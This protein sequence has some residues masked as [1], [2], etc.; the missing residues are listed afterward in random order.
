MANFIAKMSI[1]GA[2]PNSLGRRF[3][4]TALEQFSTIISGSMLHWRRSIT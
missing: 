3:M 2:S 1:L 4:S